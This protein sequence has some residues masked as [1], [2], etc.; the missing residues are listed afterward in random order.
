MIEL[1]NLS[2][3]YFLGEKTITAVEDV[4]FTINDGDVFGV[5]GLSGAG[6][7]TLV[8]CINYLEKPTEGDIVFDGTVLGSLSKKEVL[9]KRREMSMVF[10]NFNLFAQRSVI[11]NICYPL[12]IAGVSKDIAKKKARELL[13]IVGLSDRENAFPAELSGGQKQRVAIARALATDPRVLLCDEATSALDPKTT[14]SILAL[15]KDINKTLGVTIIVITHEMRV[16]EQICNRVAVMSEG[17]LIE[18]GEVK[19]VF[20]NPKSSVTRNLIMPDVSENHGTSSDAEK[21]RIVF[22]GD[23]STAPMI[24]DM[25]L[26]CKTSVNILAADIKNL[27]G[28]SYGQ[29]LLQLPD[30]EKETEKVLAYLDSHNIKYNKEVSD[31]E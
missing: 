22:E 8:R 6:K 26:T 19:E 2:K 20:T 10:Q 5:I 15:L 16:V 1:K 29:M 27:D 31:D 30:N 3:K 7:S 12:E 13:K 18:T 4:S 17:K 9:R 28:K 24:S 21:I 25:S 23:A 14:N 11:R